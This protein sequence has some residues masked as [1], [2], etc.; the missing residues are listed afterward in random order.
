MQSGSSKSKEHRV[1]DDEVVVLGRLT[2]QGVECRRRT[3]L[4]FA[5]NRRV[6]GKGEGIGLA[7]EN[8]R[9]ERD[10]H[11]SDEKGSTEFAHGAGFYRKRSVFGGSPN[12]IDDERFAGAA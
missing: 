2:A 5:A 1:Y 8:A 10:G 3:H 4:H 12:A 9:A 6:N 11:S 7:L